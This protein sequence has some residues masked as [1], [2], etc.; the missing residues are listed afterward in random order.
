VGEE[1]WRGH[2]YIHARGYCAAM[3]L[4]SSSSRTASGHI[5]A[6]SVALPLRRGHGNTTQSH[7]DN[8]TIQAQVT[9]FSSS[10]CELCEY[11]LARSLLSSSHIK[12]TSKAFA[13]I[14]RPLSMSNCATAVRVNGDCQ[15]RS[16]F[17][18]WGFSLGNLSSQRFL[19][20][21]CSTMLLVGFFG[22]DQFS[23]K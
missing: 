7:L 3:S 4:Y 20:L 17:Y 19:F 1:P 22:S 10:L 5:D 16:L 15:Y 23:G 11:L 6:I 2:G 13:A 9:R 12:R 8:N 21:G 14:I 18:E